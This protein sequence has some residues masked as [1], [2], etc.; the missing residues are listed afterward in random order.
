MKRALLAVA[1]VALLCSTGCQHLTGRPGIWAASA[2]PDADKTAPYHVA[3]P[4][5]CHKA[6]VV[7]PPGPPGPT[8]GYPYYTI[9]GPRDFLVDNPPSIG[10]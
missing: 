7:A 10:P 6:R 8:V 3:H 9:R 4:G 2:G 1:A 5:L